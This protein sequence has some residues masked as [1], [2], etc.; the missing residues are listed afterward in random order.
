MTDVVEVNPPAPEPAA[1][2]IGPRG[3]WAVSWHGLR[4]VAV[5]ELRQRVRSTRWR[6]ALAVWMVVIGLITVLSVW[7]FTA[8]TE[9]SYEPGIAV[10]EDLYGGMIY[11]VVVLFVLFLGLLV[12]P[13][14]SSGAING[15]R[16]AGTL[17]TLQVTRLSPAE[18]VLGKLL[19]S[20]TAAL[21]FLVASVPF[22]V[23]AYAAGGVE[24]VSLVTT[25]AM[26]AFVLLVVCAIGL[27]FSALVTRTSGSGVLTYLTI[28]SLV[29]V[30]PILF[31]LLAP[32][33]TVDED[34]RVWRG[35]SF[36]DTEG[37]AEACEWATE[38]R[39][40][41]HSEWTWWLL[42]PNPFVIVADAQPLTNEPEFSQTPLQLLQ[43]GARYART[44]APAYQELDECWTQERERAEMNG[45]RWESPV[46]EV[47][48]TSHPVWPWGL[49]V[50][51]VL[52]VGSV[53]LAVRR[54]R[55]PARQLPRGTRVA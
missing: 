10:E 27:G 16:N 9:P 54:L 25:I 44:G 28:G 40:V 13:T 6:L 49:A 14:L 53:V 55:T 15:D 2:E 1:P 19:A 43:T 37:Y 4:T 31:G 41:F 18:I 50:D 48:P 3:T 45:E 38:R 17:A 47:R 29:A 12:A 20:W 33:V 35:S 11:S 30:L 23:W 5:L 39:G 32:I 34:V 51:L 42:A 52:A 26:L 24:I 22:I 8:A 46:E 7:A 21:A 36:N